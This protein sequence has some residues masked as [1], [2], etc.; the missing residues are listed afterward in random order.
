MQMMTGRY[1][2]YSF[3]NLK[4]ILKIPKTNKRLPKQKR[5][6]KTSTQQTE[7]LHC[8]LL[9]QDQCPGRDVAM[10]SDASEM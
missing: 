4:F 8:K 1:L 7:C 9:K 3:Q 5:L 10:C 6:P 2:Q